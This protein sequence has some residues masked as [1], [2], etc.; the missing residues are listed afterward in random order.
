VQIV[1]QNGIELIVSANILP[2]FMAS[3]FS[4]IPIVYDYS[5]YLEE[6]ASIYYSNSVL[7]IL[8]QSTTRTLT[9]FNLNSAI[10]VTTV[11]HLFKKYLKSIGVKN[12]H[13]IPNGVAIDLLKP[14]HAERAKN[15]LNIEGTVIGYVGS[16]EY[17]LDLETV[18]Y[19]LAVLMKKTN[20]FR[21]LKLL[22]V[23]VSLYTD[24]SRYLKRIASELGIANKIIFTGAVEYQ[25]LALY[26][27]A[28]DVCI[29]PRKPILLNK[30]TIGGK[31]FDYLA[32][33]KPVLSSNTPALAQLFTEK[34]GVFCYNSKSELIKMLQKVLKCNH[35]AHQYRAVASKYDWN[36]IASKFENVLKKV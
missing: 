5:D 14:I 13:I 22:L 24:Y 9:N 12:I 17:W 18:L 2:S 8:L 30:L 35:D 32:C 33:G 1:Q 29:N 27:S 25:K 15:L 28:M 3:V 36:I 6:S 7:K 4:K 19:A 31:V 10:C 11:T 20:E 21:D 34:D 16:L 26:I 23:G